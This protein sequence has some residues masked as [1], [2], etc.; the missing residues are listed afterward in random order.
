MPLRRD[1]PAP[2][3]PLHLQLVHEQ[4]SPMSSASC[5]RCVALL[6][7]LVFARAIPDA[8][9]A[10][11][12]WFGMP[13]RGKRVVSWGENHVQKLITENMIE[14]NPWWQAVKHWKATGV[15]GRQVKQKLLFIGGLPRS[16]TTLLEVFFR[17]LK[18]VSNLHFSKEDNIHEGLPLLKGDYSKYG[19]G[20]KKAYKGMCSV[21]ESGVLKGKAALRM[22]NSVP[23][24]QQDP[25]AYMSQFRRA[26][27]EGW[28]SWNFSKPVLAVKDPPNLLRMSFLQKAFQETHDVFAI[29]TL[30]HPLEIATR[31]SCDPN[32]AEREAIGQNWLNCHYQWLDDLSQI[33]NYLVIPYEAWFNHPQATGRAI[34]Q[35]LHL[36]KHVEVSLPRRLG[37][38]KRRRLVYRGASKNSF[39]LSRKF[40]GHCRKSGNWTSTFKLQESAEEFERFGYNISNSMQLDKPRAFELCMLGGVPCRDLH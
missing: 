39:L 8:T 21:N 33:R 23:V 16:G 29:F 36:R 7:S 40:F 12:G 10:E 25:D 6:A 37:S 19:G 32:S 34:E 30:M 9:N 13:S 24:E 35:F 15:R 17:S 31:Y 5:L 3:L 20:S 22:Q 1:S 38:R 18:S 27:W 2:S 4:A 26:A 14:E 11:D 28:Q